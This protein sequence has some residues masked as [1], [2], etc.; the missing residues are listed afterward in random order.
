MERYEVFRPETVPTDSGGLER[1]M[2]LAG[3]FMSHALWCVSTGESLIPLIG[4]EGRQGWGL[5]RMRDKRLE[6]GVARGE[7]WI[8]SNPER[9]ERAALIFDGYYTGGARR[10][11]ALL[12]KVVDYEGELWRIGLV[13]PYRHANDA[14]GFAVHRPKF[15]DV[16]DR[17]NEAD[18]PRLMEAFFRG[19][20]L[21]EEGAAI[22]HSTLDESL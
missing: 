6:E 9:V 14:A 7:R 4:F 3:F 17:D 5:L 21:H 16:D 22:W 12:G 8:D 11:D 2:E 10:T 19:S 1:T 15:R 13:L 18:A 20:D